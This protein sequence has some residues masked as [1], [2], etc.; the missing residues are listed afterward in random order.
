MRDSTPPLLV[1]FVGLPGVGKSTLAAGLVE[2]LR[3]DGVKVWTPVSNV[4]NVESH[5][6]RV[7]RKATYVARYLLCRPTVAAGWLR[8]FQQNP[9]ASAHDVVRTGFNW[10]FVAGALRSRRISNGVTVADQGLFQ[11]YWSAVLGDPNP[12]A[13]SVH[14]VMETELSEARL[15]VILVEADPDVVRRRLAARADNPSRVSADA[16]VETGSESGMLEDEGYSLEQAWTAYEHVAD[17]LAALEGRYPSLSVV[18]CRNDEV[19]DIRRNVTAIRDTLSG[20]R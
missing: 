5:I 17:S 14:R 16:D 1:E 3:D 8:T 20:D 18:R 4:N 9:N 6:H 13:Y 10:L 7:P 2:V 12:P 19:D 15:V 11:A